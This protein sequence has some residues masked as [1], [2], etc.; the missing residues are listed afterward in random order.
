MIDEII[1]YLEETYSLTDEDLALPDDERNVL[2]G[3]RLIIAQI[4]DIR[5][6]GL[7]NKDEDEL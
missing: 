2:I 4:K 7:P 3:Q 6:N 5:E 1:E